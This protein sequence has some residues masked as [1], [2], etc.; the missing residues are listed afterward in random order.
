MDTTQAATFRHTPGRGADP[1]VLLLGC[2]VDLDVGSA[3]S[4]V[5]AVMAQTVLGNLDGIEVTLRAPLGG[6]RHA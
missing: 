4:Q 6:E 3:L 1:A 2:V 5:F